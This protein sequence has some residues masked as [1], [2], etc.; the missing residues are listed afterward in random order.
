MSK[1]LKSPTND[2]KE[3]N[4]KIKPKKAKILAVGRKIEGNK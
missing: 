2:L 1:I 3:F 4:L